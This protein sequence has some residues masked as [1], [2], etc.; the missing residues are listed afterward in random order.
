M[1]GGKMCMEVKCLGGNTLYGKSSMEGFP[2]MDLSWIA[3]VWPLH[4]FLTRN[5]CS[6]T[7]ERR[8]PYL[9]DHKVSICMIPRRKSVVKK[10]VEENCV[11]KQTLGLLRR[12]KSVNSPCPDLA[13]SR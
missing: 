12:D 2:E 5:E 4:Y 9:G 7:T 6:G 13:R 1:V 8:T 10:H 11:G 3:K